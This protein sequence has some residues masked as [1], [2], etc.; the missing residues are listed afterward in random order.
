MYATTIQ[1]DYAVMRGYRVMEDT[2]FGTRFELIVPGGAD[3]HIWSIRSGW[4]T[5][6]MIEGS[7]CNHE[8]F[9]TLLEAL[10]RPVTGE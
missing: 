5:A 6:D 3:R 8:K 1:K 2:R 9:G 7:Y 10:D 4:Q